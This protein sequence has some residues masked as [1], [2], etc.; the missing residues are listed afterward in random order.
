MNEFMDLIFSQNDALNVDLAKISMVQADTIK[1]ENGQFLNDIRKD[2]EQL[3]EIR[4]RNQWKLF[5]QRNL[6]NIS[7]DLLN[8][9][10]E[11]KYMVE[12]K[13]FYKVIERRTKI[14]DYLK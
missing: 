13:D 2:A 3:K 10:K 9:D 5:I 6:N 14:P 4:A 7:L 8:I 12:S 1:T 11:K